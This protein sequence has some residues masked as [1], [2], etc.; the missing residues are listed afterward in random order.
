[1][2]REHRSASYLSGAKPE[3]Q[4]PRRNRRPVIDPD[5]VEHASIQAAA[6]A[7]RIWP[8]AVYHRCV[9]GHEG[10]H[11]LDD[12]LIEPAPIPGTAG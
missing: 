11:F 1:M 5:G 4:P 2:P 10:W 8:A 6:H 12:P 9:K 3:R 7:H